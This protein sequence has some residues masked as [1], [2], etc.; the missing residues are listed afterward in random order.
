MTEITTK[1]II[2]IHE[3]DGWRHNL[4]VPKHRLY[5]NFERVF[6]SISHLKNTVRCQHIN[7]IFNS[8]MNQ[9]KQNFYLKI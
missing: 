9:I 7:S 1:L 3:H 8:K 5:A 6:T 2:L 4:Q